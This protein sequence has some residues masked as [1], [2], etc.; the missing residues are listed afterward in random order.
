MYSTLLL[1]TLPVSEPE[2]LVEL[3][4][5]NTNEP[6][7]LGC[8]TS[9]PGFRMFRDENEVLSGLFAFAPAGELNAIYNGEA[10]LATGL[11]ATGDMHNVLGVSP[12]LGRLLNP[13]DDAA[14]APPVAVLSHSY[15]QR[16]FGGD[17]RVIGQ[18]LRLNTSAVTIVGVTAAAFR[19]I[20][21]GAS[22]DI[23]L[24]M[25]SSAELFRGKGILENGGNWWLRIIGRRKDGIS[26]QQV[27][28]SLEPIFQR[29]IEHSMSSLPGEFA[30]R[31][32]GYVSGIH[33]R[34]QPAAA[35]GASEFRRD[36]DRPLR[37]LMAVVSFILLIAC[38][39]L[40]SLLL[41]R[42][43]A[44]R[45]EF[46]VRLAIGAGRSRLARQLL[47]E[48]L[49][50]SAMGGALGLMMAQWSGSVFL[51]M[52]SGEIGLR[53]VELKPDV[54]VFLFT[55]TVALLSGILLGLGPILHLTKADPQAAL[56]DMG[57]KRVSSKLAHLLVPAQVALATILLIGAGLLLR[58][59]QNFRRIDLGF[60]SEKLITVRVSP[61]LV[62]YNAVRTRSYLHELTTRLEALPSVR[63]V[64]L[65]SDPLGAL[66][67]TT[68]VEVPGFESAPTMQRTT[69]RNRVGSRFI[70]T[71][72]LKLLRGRDFSAS[73]NES[74]PRIAVVNE[75]FAQHFFRTVDVIGRQFA[76]AAQKSLPYVIVGVVAD[77]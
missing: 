4:C 16:R 65:S 67:N 9:Y 66:G 27:Q 31:I 36:L 48:S 43:A 1:K 62:G 11:L 5:V 72:G 30:S 40:A 70:E 12:A 57:G 64:T 52:G 10:E 55:A 22:P 6:D 69:G 13:S 44:R 35:G 60:R 76:F 47:T 51:K 32:R 56:R 23:T 71:A 2:Q 63:S 14:S 3:G 74:S 18:I 54:P 26:I 59:F 34:V 7:K 50:L 45:C 58:T 37:I 38:A 29:T 15:W 21:L 19:G 42:T 75:S 33:F 49:L 28:A 41:S 61:G 8:N 73:D 39:N 77:A 25:G 24:A 68:L 17:A 46:G 53:A 20:T